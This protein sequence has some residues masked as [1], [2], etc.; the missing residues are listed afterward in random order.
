MDSALPPAES[1][2]RFRHAMTPV[3]SLDRF[4]ATSRDELLRRFAVALSR[5]DTSALRALTMTREEFAYLY[6]PESQYTRPPHLMAPDVVWMLMQRRS[7][8]GL[9]RLASRLG[10]GAATI[11]THSCEPTPVEQGASRLFQDCSVGYRRAGTGSL[12]VRRLFGSILE[13]DGRYKF[14][15]FANDY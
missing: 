10:G 12:E 8:R 14:V 4:S 9:G 3:R 6:F 15:S 11:V 1:L 7:E 13:R 5:D 2:R